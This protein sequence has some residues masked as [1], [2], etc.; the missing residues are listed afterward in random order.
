MAAAALAFAISGT[1]GLPHSSSILNG[2]S[3]TSP[4]PSQLRGI[5]D[6][7][8]NPEAIQK[9]GDIA[10]G[11][12]PLNGIEFGPEDEKLMIGELEKWN[13]AHLDYA[14]L[15]WFQPDDFRDKYL[16]FFL[17][18]IQRSKYPNFKLS[19]I[20]EQ[21]SNKKHIDQTEKDTHLTHLRPYLNHPNFLKDKNGRPTL[22]VFAQENEGIIDNPGYSQGWSEAANKYGLFIILEDYVGRTLNPHQSDPGIGWFNYGYNIWD[23]RPSGYDETRDVI[24]ISFGYA[25]AGDFKVIPRNNHRIEED[26]KTAISSAVP[27]VLFVSDD[28]VVEKTNADPSVFGILGKEIPQREL[29]SI[30]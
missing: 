28:E 24:R 30:K 25:K 14:A 12:T 15:S 2:R 7:G 19:I 1:P 13:G 16:Q 17:D 9:S 27:I 11:F 22:F 4:N 3:E 26:T 8:F 5:A 23:L 21:D 20:Y 6:Y 18:V 29:A 10:L